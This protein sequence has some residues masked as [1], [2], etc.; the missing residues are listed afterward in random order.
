MAFTHIDEIKKEDKFAFQSM[1]IIWVKWAVCKEYK[2][3]QRKIR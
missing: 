1:L 2:L 3:Y